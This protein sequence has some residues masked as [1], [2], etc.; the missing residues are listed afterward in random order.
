L[1][2]FL[3]LNYFRF[4][5]HK[6]PAKRAVT[7][8]PATLGHIGINAPATVTSNSKKI[9]SRCIAE[10]NNKKITTIIV[11]GFIAPPC[12]AKKLA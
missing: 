8:H 3:E 6:K 12:S 10:I 5:R 9:L 1:P 2:T 4:S 11:T 7:I